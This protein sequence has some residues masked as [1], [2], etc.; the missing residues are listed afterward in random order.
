MNVNISDT[1]VPAS[2]G[3]FFVL[4]RARIN[5]NAIFVPQRVYCALK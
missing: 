2:A 4:L 3:T 5:K 1:R